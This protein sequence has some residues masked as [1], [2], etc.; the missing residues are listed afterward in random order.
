[1]G[2]ERLG[3]LFQ[4]LSCPIL[5]ICPSWNAKMLASVL[6]KTGWVATQRGAL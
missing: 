1:M 2:E 4:I 3:N 5:G 6:A